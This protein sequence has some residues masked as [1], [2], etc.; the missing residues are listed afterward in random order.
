MRG[1]WIPSLSAMLLAGCAAATSFD[2]QMNG[3]V[4]HGESDLV[5]LLGAPQQINLLKDNSRV[6]TYVRKET[7]Q[8]GAPYQAPPARLTGG[9]YGGSSGV[10]FTP[11][12]N[13]SRMQSPGSLEVLSCTIAF[14]LVGDRVDSW[15]SKGD[16]CTAKQQK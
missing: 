2:A 16:D 11:S 10:M 15:Q 9:I 3:L 14:R 13:Y 8:Q 7:A 12:A 4:G 5:A 1:L 6:L